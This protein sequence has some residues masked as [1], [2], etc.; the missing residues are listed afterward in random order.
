MWEPGKLGAQL[1]ALAGSPSAEMVT[2]A[3]VVDYRGRLTVRRA[4][5]SSVDH[6]ALLRSRMA[7]LHSSSFLI[8]RESLIDGIG[9]VDETLPRSM[10][11]DWDLLLRAARRHPI[12]HV[13]EPL[14]RVAWG[15]SSYFAEQWQDRND[16]RLWLLRHHPEMATDRRGAALTYGKLAF[17]CAALHRRSE[18]WRW[19]GRTVRTDWREPRAYLAAAVLLGVVRWQAVVAALNRRGHGI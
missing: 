11:E 8:R 1:A 5:R 13:D 7:M 4:G 16:A 10:A 9:L 17:G 15:G 2:T 3:M 14:V 18:G 19:I 6:A 12:V